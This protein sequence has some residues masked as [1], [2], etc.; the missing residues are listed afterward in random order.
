MFP[1]TKIFLFCLY[2]KRSKS[3]IEPKY[4]SIFPYYITLV[5][6][7]YRDNTCKHLKLA[8]FYQITIFSP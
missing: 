1:L 4:R 2:F 7:Q 3:D 6:L 5:I 8:N